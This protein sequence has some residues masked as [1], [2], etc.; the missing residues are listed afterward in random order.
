MGKNYH[1]YDFTEYKAYL[2]HRADAERGM[3]SA[4]AKALNCQSAY[5]SQ[6]LN[7]NA[8]LS[9]EQGDAA[10]H[11][12]AHSDKESQYFLLL[13]QEER[14]G[15]V[16]LKKF[17][18]QQLKSFKAEQLSYLNRKNIRDSLTPEQQAVYYSSWEYNAIHMAVTIPRLRSKE[19]LLTAFRI[20]E[21]RLNA[22]LEF[23]LESGL[24]KQQSDKYAPG[25]TENFL[26]RNSPLVRQLHLNTRAQALQS[27]DRDRLEDAHYSVVVTLSQKDVLRIK[28]LINEYISEVVDIAR[29]SK[30][31][32]IYGLS[33]D[34]FDFEKDKA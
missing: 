11:F 18:T 31:D 1:L 13:L 21:N 5:I 28:K 33:L 10:N 23:L 17:F 2:R 34:F 3:K 19:A 6:V 4:L 26:E 25:T 14:A 15:T 30:E 12:F 29:A 22:C 27:L 7:E 32:V 9:L 16:S 8:Q 24:I 20:P